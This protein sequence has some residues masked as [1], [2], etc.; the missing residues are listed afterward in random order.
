MN[1]FL[2]KR[3][4]LT[5]LV[6]VSSA[7]V[8]FAA[9]VIDRHGG[10]AKLSGKV[11]GVSKDKV[12]FETSKG[13][14]LEIPVNEIDEIIWEGEPA[15]LKSAR[16]NEAAGKLSL[17]SDGFAKA[18]NDNKSNRPEIKLD[19]DY[20]ALRT[21]AR[22]ALTDPAKVPDVL[23][24]LNEF[25]SKNGDSRHFYDGTLLQVD[26][27]LV[28]KDAGEARKAADK[29]GKAAGGDQ[30]IGAQIAMARVDVLE[31][32]V[33]EAQKVLE[34]VISGAAGSPAEEARKLEARL[35]LANCLQLKSQFPDAIKLL[36]EVI[37]QSDAENSRLQA[38][39]YVRQGDC[40]QAA[41]KS[42]EALL[43]YL[44][45]DVLFSSEK[46]FHPEALYHLSRLWAAIQ[47]PE[48]ANEA[49]DKL[50]VE[51]PNS[52]WTEKLKAPAGASGS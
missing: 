25:Q 45:V 44:H 24:K 32:K 2:P 49:A 47:Q 21:S 17:A 35:V 16:I 12:S 13:E 3:F 31:N 28:V 50:S 37:K 39:A 26:L 20:F 9:D 15:A 36:D 30:K 41:G 38:E 29:L 10:G 22:A 52:P 46:A 14:K 18:A 6:L 7:C 8:T 34:T 33:D 1:H 42:K 48:R 23:K 19:I 43:A 11:T 40:Y 5:V 4:A 27:N 51:Y